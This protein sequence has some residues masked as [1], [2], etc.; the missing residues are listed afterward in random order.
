MIFS[1]FELLQ[2]I[3]KVQID[4]EGVFLKGSLNGIRNGCRGFVQVLVLSG[5]L[6]NGSSGLCGVP[7]FLKGGF[8]CFVRL[9]KE[10]SRGH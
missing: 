6:V 7:S 2:F 4:Q 8:Q 10:G 1:V 3:L 9:L 5:F